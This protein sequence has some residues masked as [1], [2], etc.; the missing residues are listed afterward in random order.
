MQLKLAQLGGKLQNR[1]NKLFSIF[2]MVGATVVPSHAYFH[3]E[4]H[5]TV[6]FSAIIIT[7]HKARIF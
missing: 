4:A 6:R 1:R 2:V 7:R 3:L 5:L